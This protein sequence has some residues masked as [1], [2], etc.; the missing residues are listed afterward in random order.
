ML[1]ILHSSLC[2]VFPL[3]VM[4]ELPDPGYGERR[5]GRPRLYEVISRVISGV[6]KNIQPF[7]S[8]DV[9][10]SLQVARKPKFPWCSIQLCILA[11]SLFCHS[12][13]LEQLKLIRHTRASGMV[14]SNF[15]MKASSKIGA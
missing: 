11:S 7:S 5:N 10:C 6:L 14:M 15:S 8:A 4:H 2:D 13:A 12:E 9:V 3:P 1:C